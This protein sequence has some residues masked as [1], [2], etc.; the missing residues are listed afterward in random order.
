VR[1]P[2]QIFGHGVIEELV[3]VL[4]LT[5]NGALGIP[6]GLVSTWGLVAVEAILEP[7][8]TLI[9]RKRAKAASAVS[10]NQPGCF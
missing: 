8:T 9:R 6:R 2:R 5:T 7:P 10:Q 3:I 1:A 4:E